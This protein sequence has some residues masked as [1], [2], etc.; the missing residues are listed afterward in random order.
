MCMSHAKTPS[1]NQFILT[2]CACNMIQ[3]RFYDTQRFTAD[4]SVRK[5]TR[6]LFILTEINTH[7]FH[8][9][10]LPGFFL[11]TFSVR[12]D[13]FS[14]SECII[15]RRFESATVS[16]CTIAKMESF[17]ILFDSF[18]WHKKNFTFLVIN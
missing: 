15:N 9:S 18:N 13:F 11:L 4:V 10:S 5:T 14:S 2:I 7:K 8:A 6:N 12:C 16:F 1:P 17:T 3:H